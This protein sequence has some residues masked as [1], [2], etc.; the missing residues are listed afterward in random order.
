MVPITSP[1]PPLGR[2]Y[3]ILLLLNRLLIVFFHYLHITLYAVNYYDP[4]SSS[5]SVYFV[6]VGIIP[7]Y[8]IVIQQVALLILLP[9]LSQLIAV[10]PQV[11]L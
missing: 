3:A 9:L 2:R 8:I 6:T 1:S 11:L 4:R 7:L 5:L 10:V